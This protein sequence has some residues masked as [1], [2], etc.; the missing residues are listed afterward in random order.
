MSHSDRVFAAYIHAGLSHGFH[1]GFNRQGPWLKA[2]QSNHPSA[3]TN[4][5]VVSNFIRAERFA[6][7][8]VGPIS[9]K[10]AQ[11][12]HTSPIGLVPKSHQVDMFRM[13]VDLSFHSVNDSI[14]LS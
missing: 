6:G 3:A 12:V 1:I 9:C 4:E 11:N 5:S 10:A 7:R 13:I 2:S 14:P 8:L